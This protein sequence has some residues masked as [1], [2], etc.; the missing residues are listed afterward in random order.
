MSL[1]SLVCAGT[2]DITLYAVACWSPLTG[3]RT[4]TQHFAATRLTVQQPP[5]VVSVNG[6]SSG[7]TMQLSTGDL[8]LDVSVFDPSLVRS[9]Y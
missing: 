5:L 8:S 9:L 2:Y 7:S 1:L 3:G 6:Y 4:C